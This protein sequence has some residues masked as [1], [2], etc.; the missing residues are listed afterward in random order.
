MYFIGNNENLT[1][2]GE[3]NDISF[4][5]ISR[6]EEY[7]WTN[8]YTPQPPPPPPPPI[9]HSFGFV[10]PIGCNVILFS[11]VVVYLFVSFI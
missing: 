3:I 2:R 8:V 10:R 4:L 6:P 1:L 7:V 11:L 5:D 9:T